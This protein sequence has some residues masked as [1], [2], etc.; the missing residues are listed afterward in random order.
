[1]GEMIQHAPARI[2]EVRLTHVRAW[3]AE[4]PAWAKGLAWRHIRAVVRHGREGHPERAR[5]A[6]TYLDLLGARVVVDEATKDLLGVERTR[7]RQ[8]DDLGRFIRS[9]GAI[10]RRGDAHIR[11]QQGVATAVDRELERLA[12]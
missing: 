8:D 10:A 9:A 11:I 1:M 6:A 2:A 5:A 4:Q 12:V 3:V 7:T